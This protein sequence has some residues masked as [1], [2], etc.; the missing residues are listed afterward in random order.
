MR[1]RSTNGPRESER[2]VVRMILAS[3][4]RI[5]GPSKR[6]RLERRVHFSKVRSRNPMGSKQLLDHE[7][8]EAV[9]KLILNRGHG[10]FCRSIQILTYHQRCPALF[11]EIFD[12]ACQSPPFIVGVPFV[13][14]PASMV[15][16]AIDESCDLSAHKVV[17]IE[18]HD[19][20]SR[21][22]PR[23]EYADRQLRAPVMKDGLS[24]RL[25]TAVIAGWREIDYDR[26]YF[27]WSGKAQ[28][29][30]SYH[31]NSEVPIILRAHRRKCPL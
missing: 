20:C 24:T 5:H 29:L 22:L 1:Q 17:C 3:F 18:A 2:F 26:L 27:L 12:V 30:V 8:P 28:W 6:Q 13:D 10:Q 31:D 9:V 4:K 7:L 19:M 16:V 21:V 14:V 25:R 23:G 11:V 15:G